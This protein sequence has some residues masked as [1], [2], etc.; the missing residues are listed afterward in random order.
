MTTVKTSR[1]IGM[2]VE[3]VF[4]KFTDVEHSPAAV[5]AIKKIEMLTPGG[6]RLGARWRETRQVFGRLDDADMEVT[7]FEP[8]HMYTITHRKAGLRI[9]TTFRFRPVRGGTKVTV[10]FALGERGVLPRLLA[11]LGWVLRGEVAEVL[12][13]DLADLQY[14]LEH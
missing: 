12:D 10:E 3:Y 8:N 4:R 7:S 2:P 1:D 6:M 9:D 13:H 14:S 5:S 11:P